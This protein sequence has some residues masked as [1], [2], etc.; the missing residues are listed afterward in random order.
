MIRNWRL[1]LAAALLACCGAAGLAHAQTYPSRPI[2]IVVPYPAGGVTDNLVRL[3][4]ER[5]KNSLGQ[6]IVVENIGGGGG[7]MSNPKFVLQ[8]VDP[9]GITARTRA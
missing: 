4:A 2:T 5:M 1:L 9:S 3:L 7:T 8:G 6:S